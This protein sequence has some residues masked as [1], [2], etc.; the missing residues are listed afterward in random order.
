MQSSKT[1]WG[2]FVQKH[3]VQNHELRWALIVRL[4]LDT[5]AASVSTS[6]KLEPLLCNSSFIGYL[7]VMTFNTTI[8]QK[9]LQVN[10]ETGVDI[11]KCSSGNAAVI[12]RMLV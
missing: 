7:M 11:V 2:Y 5:A 6:D 1:D 10:T 9:Y 8:K 4:V 12:S 3:L